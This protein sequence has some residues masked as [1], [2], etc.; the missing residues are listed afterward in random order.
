VLNEMGADPVGRRELEARLRAP[1]A[2]SAS[3]FF[4]ILFRRRS[5]F[6]G[7]MKV[8]KDVTRPELLGGPKPEYTPEA[9]QARVVGNVIMMAMIDRE[10][11]VRQAR[12][13]K[14]QPFGLGEAAA[15]AV[16]RWTFRPATYQNRPVAVDYVLTVTFQPDENPE[17][18]DRRG[19]ASSSG[20]R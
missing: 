19:A 2:G 17:P 7:K 11:C 12:V 1:N 15:A 13:L 9:R 4:V 5:T 3:Y 20:S 14:G 16:R 18:A 6:R 8:G 10:G